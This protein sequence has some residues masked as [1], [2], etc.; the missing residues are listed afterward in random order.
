MPTSIANPAILNAIDISK[1]AGG[2]LQSGQPLTQW[3]G[4][5]TNMPIQKLYMSGAV[6]RD[7]QSFAVAAAAASTAYSTWI[8]LPRATL[9]TAVYFVI[10][11]APTGAN[12]TLAITA[13][14]V[15]M[16]SAANYAVTSVTPINTIIA[17]PLSTV[18]AVSPVNAAGQPGLPYLP[19]SGTFPYPLLVTYTEGATT[20]HSTNVGIFVEYEPDDFNG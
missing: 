4:I 19:L 2:E 8:C 5:R 11:T 1:N 9:I 3:N 14:G 15:S 13:N 18:L 6:R 17:V 16:L 20:V 10:G 7:L 12:A